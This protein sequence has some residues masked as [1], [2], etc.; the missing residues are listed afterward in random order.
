MSKFNKEEKIKKFQDI[1]NTFRSG[2]IILDVDKRNKNSSDLYVFIHCGNDNHDGYWCRWYDVYP[3]NQCHCKQC[4][5]DNLL[6]LDR[7][8][9][10]LPSKFDNYNIIE[11]FIKNGYVWVKYHCGNPDHKVKS[12]DLHAMVAGNACKE[13]YSDRMR[14]L[15]FEEKTKQA[16]YEKLK[17]FNLTICDWNGCHSGSMPFYC[18]DAEGYI[19]CV[20]YDMLKPMKVFSAAWI[21]S[22]PNSKKYAIENIKN[23]CLISRPDYTIV[24]NEYFGMQKKYIFKYLGEQIDGEVDKNFKCTLNDFIYA[25]IG[26]PHI[27]MSKGEQKTYKHLKENHIKF[28]TQ[29]KF[30]DCKRKLTLPFDFY[31]PDYNCCVEYQG[32]QHYIAREFFGGEKSFKAQIERDEIKRDYCIDNN[33][34]LIEI[35]YWEYNKLEIFLNEKLKDVMNWQG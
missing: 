3:R 19:Y 26:H 34:N 22:S 21:N 12:S 11:S 1:M 27:T 18:K 9:N 32:E 15:L 2:F 17:E 10:K 8:K 23:Y 24:S 33:I 35:P 13:C 5:V 16:I 7:I 31:L 4:I 28:E 25:E 29:Y 14:G 30:D 6:D 20:R